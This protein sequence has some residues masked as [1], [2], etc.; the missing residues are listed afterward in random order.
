MRKKVT[1]RRDKTYSKRLNT[2]LNDNKVP[3]KSNPNEITMLKQTKRVFNASK[4]VDFKDDKTKC[5]FNNF[6]TKYG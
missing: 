2:T 5:Q 3:K 4:F 1:N 6:V